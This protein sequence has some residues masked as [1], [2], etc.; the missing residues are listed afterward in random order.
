MEQEELPLN[1][2]NSQKYMNVVS[3]FTV[4]HSFTYSFA[5]LFTQQTFPEFL[6]YPRL[7]IGKRS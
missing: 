7:G 3:V 2:T 6:F 4:I 5:S 1:P